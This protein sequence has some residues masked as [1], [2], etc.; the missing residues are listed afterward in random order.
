MSTLGDQ[1]RAT[2]A[3]AALQIEQSKQEDA[4]R[5]A[6]ERLDYDVKKAEILIRDLPQLFGQAA[7][8][9]RTS[10]DV[11]ILEKD[12]HFKGQD[13]RAASREYSLHGVTPANMFGGA[14]VVAKWICDKGLKIGFREDQRGDSGQG[15]SWTD[16]M[17][18]AYWN[19]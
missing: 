18:V 17:L 1:L 15:R 2:A 13:T 7:Q 12:L 9:G 11:M 5:H 19:K 3:A 16:L 14:W 8:R 4:H 10:F 6:Q